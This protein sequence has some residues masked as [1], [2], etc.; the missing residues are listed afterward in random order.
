[1]LSRSSGFCWKRGLDLQHHAV[2]V[3]LRE[4]RRDL[5]LAE[6]VVERVVDHL[7]RDAEPRRGVAVD[8]QARLQP[9]VLLVA[10][11]VAQ[12]GQRLQAA[13]RAAAPRRASSSASAILEAVLVLR[14]ADAVLDRQVLHRLHEERDARRPWPARGCSRRMTSL[15]LALR[16]SS[17]FR[18]IWMRPLFSVVFV[19][20]MPMNDDRLSTAG[21]LQDHARPAPA[22]ARPSRRTR[23]SAAPRRCPGSRRCP[24]PGRSPSG[25]RRRAGPS[26]TSV[27]TATS[28]VAVWCR[29]TQL[30]RAAVERR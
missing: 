30:Q 25:R 24:A 8:H 3:Q 13:R 17:G 27:A 14:A 12:L 10:G 2:L 9:R 20:S 7:R 19:P 23:R 6:R 1:M 4:H 28:S 18:L 29:S 16:S 26:A 11:D 15:A 21:S 22:A 5:P